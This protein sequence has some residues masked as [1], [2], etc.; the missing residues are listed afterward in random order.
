MR[1]LAIEPAMIHRHAWLSGR[2]AA[3]EK[4]AELKATSDDAWKDL[5]DGITKAWASLSDAMK[6]AKD[7]FK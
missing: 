1:L 7:R 2:D 5:E 6:S 3:N 4:L